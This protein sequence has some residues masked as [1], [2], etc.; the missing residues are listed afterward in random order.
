MKEL[1]TFI[2]LVG[3]V[4]ILLRQLKNDYEKLKCKLEK[5]DFI[6]TT[7]KFIKRKNQS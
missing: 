3:Y 7:M 6:F 4:L 2:I 1:F 5:I